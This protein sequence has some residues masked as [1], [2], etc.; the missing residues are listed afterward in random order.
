VV[1]GFGSIQ[2][3]TIKQRMSK[4]IAKFAAK[5]ITKLIA[6]FILRAVAVLVGTVGVL[7]AFHVGDEAD[8][9]LSAHAIMLNGLFFPLLACGYCL[10][11]SYL[12]LFKF[13]PTAIRL[14]CATA[15]LWLWVV[16]FMGDAK[17]PVLIKLLTFAL[18]LF[19]CSRASR[20]LVGLFFPPA[21]KINGGSPTPAAASLA[22]DSQI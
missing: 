20:R 6:I 11:V 9:F 17:D 7:L 8:W 14:I 22:P 2:P 1:E 19:L 3:R 13:S 5:L 16:L 21:P 12:V 15:A 10:Y 18:M 4:P